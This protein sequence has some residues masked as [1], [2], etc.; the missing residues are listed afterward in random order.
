[1]ARHYLA[2]SLLVLFTAVDGNAVIKS[3]D[4]T[5]DL[6]AVDVSLDDSGALV[7]VIQNSGIA[8]DTP[9]Q[10]ALILDGHTTRTFSFGGATRIQT[11]PAVRN[12]PQ[13]L[14]LPFQKGERRA[15]KFGDVGV[16]ICSGNHTLELSVDT[17]NAIGEVSESNNERSETL[18]TPCPDLAVQSIKKN[19]NSSHTQY[20]AE[21]VIIN[22]GTGKTPPFSVATQATPGTGI[23][24]MPGGG[25]TQYSP[26]APGQTLK[27][28]TGVAHAIE[29]LRVKVWLD[30]GNVVK[31][32]NEDNNVVEKLLM[33]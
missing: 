31:E 7:A 18:A 30:V 16:D 20:V 32:S 6:V 1:M 11:S 23:G 2:I 19:Y 8:I 33:P 29:S 9:F 13:N 3:T 24:T 22:Q 28:T 10:A 4:N 26:L 17:G 21:I 27:I 15:L 25:A 14:T 12:T 5:P